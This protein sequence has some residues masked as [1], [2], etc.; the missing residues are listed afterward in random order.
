MD[1]I[2]SAPVQT[3]TIEGVQ[4]SQPAVTPSEVVE[5]S[6]ETKPETVEQPVVETASE[7]TSTD[8]VKDETAPDVQGETTPETPDVKRE[9]RR[10]FM[11]TQ[12][13]GGFELLKEAH[14]L[15]SAIQDP[16]VDA[17]VK[18]QKL[19]Q[20]A[21]RAY[22][23]LKKGLFFSYWDN[24][25]QQELLIQEKFGASPAEIAEA[26]AARGNVAPSS[27]TPA[28]ATSSVPTSEELAVM[29]N[30]EIAQR[31]QD[32][33]KQ[34]AIP[35]AVQQKLTRLEELEKQFPQLK[36]QVDTFAQQQEAA[37]QQ[38]IQK[39]GA[40]FVQEAMSPVVRMMEEAGLKVSPDDT[41]DEKA[42]KE[43]AWDS[44]LTRS[45]NDL[46]TADA[47]RPLADDIQTF[48]EKGDRTAA[49]SKMRLAQARA[50]M[51]A[52]KRIP[53]YTS[54]RQQQREAQTSI[55]GKD[56]LPVIT[57]GQSSLGSTQAQP[58]G[59][60]AWNDPAEAERWKDIASSVA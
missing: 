8:Q 58:T 11:E 10:V 21:P 23:E 4:A 19:Y 22:E 35:T 51:A 49:W 15:Q 29:S 60:E 42:W 17:E 57:G 9:A 32:I 18:L 46:I 20:A 24:P 54:Q 27:T 53:L 2:W 14:D 16:S 33:Q 28:Q 7:E 59:R 41:P 44:I 52:A 43:E 26:L 1:D 39:L 48:I 34:Q 55:L 31:F 6:T 38:E 13:L 3:E 12:K 36:S 56:R 25:A 50:E 30:E 5:P 37:K 40:E 45:Y 47:N